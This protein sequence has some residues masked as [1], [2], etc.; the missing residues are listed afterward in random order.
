MPGAEHRPTVAVVTPYY[1]P[2]LGGVQ[3]YAERIVSRL[4]ADG[5][6]TVVVTTGDTRVGVRRELV[7]GVRIY[8][9]PVA[10]RWSSTPLHPGWPGLLR[11]IFELERVAIVNTHAPVVG[12]ADLAVRA[13]AGRPVVA[14]Y[15]AGSMAKGATV[16]DPLLR[17]YERYLLPRTFARAR[18]VVAVSP[19]ALGADRPNAEIISP[20][21]D[22]EVFTPTAAPRSPFRILFVGRMDASSAWKGVHVLI[23]AFARV[24]RRVPGAE[25]R[26]VGSGDAVPGL[27]AR[28]A[29]LG[30]L[31]AVTFTGRR[32]GPELVAEY[33]QAAVTV[34]PS[35]TA[36]E[37]FG[38]T[39]IEAMACG[40]PVIGSR[41]GGI[42]YVVTPGVDGLLVA[43]GDVAELA[44]ACGRVL[45][46]RSFADRLSVA[47]CRSATAE[48]TWSSRLDR[49]AELLHPD[50]ASTPAAGVTVTTGG[51]RR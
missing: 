42:P 21:V 39:L 5:V 11:R 47:G 18:T 49:W 36:A 26:C 12:L 41:V 25:L 32:D 38:M 28:A 35:L 9:L 33:Q 2:S 46:D 22:V 23:E 7:D 50:P 51:S 13:A 31:D 16:I 40:S 20:G 44:D 43:P 14:T 10:V 48:F 1:P 30:C 34:L 4:R 17:A 24:R 8:R 29:D 15:H 6:P 19:T 3:Q 45:T 37:S 27:R